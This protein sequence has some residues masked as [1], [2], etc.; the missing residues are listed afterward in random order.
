MSL[1][2]METD[3]PVFKNIKII[4]K[5]TRRC[6]SII[7]NLMKFARQDEPDMKPASLNVIIEDAITLVD[8]QMGVSQ[9]TL[10]KDLAKDLPV[11]KADSNQLIQVLMNIF[12]NAQQAMDGEPGNISIRSSSPNAGVVEV[13]ITDTGPGMPEEV[14]TK[15]FEPFFTTKEAGKGTGLGLAVTYG[16]VKDHGGNI[17]VES[18]E[19]EGSTFIITLPVTTSA[20][21]KTEEDASQEQ[22]PEPHPVKPAADDDQAA[23]GPKK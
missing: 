19:G 17:R 18:R 4:E 20:A 21:G 7:E 15:I 2:K 1:K 9:V 12:I 6:N 8:H 14:R 23:A 16:I 10:E 13:R 3:S 22:T 5:E 11:V